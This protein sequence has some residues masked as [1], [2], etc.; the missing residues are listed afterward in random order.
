MNIVF[1]LG[2]AILFGNIPVTFNEISVQSFFLISLSLII[3]II[4]KL[5]NGINQFLGLLL[6][7]SYLIFI[8]FNFSKV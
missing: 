7:I 6:M 1:V 3:F 4:F 5:K 8:Y 2:L